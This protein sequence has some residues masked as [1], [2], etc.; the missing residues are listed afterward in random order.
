M[1]VRSLGVLDLQD[2]VPVGLSD[3]S[4]TTSS[5]GRESRTGSGQSRPGIAS[6]TSKPLLRSHRAVINLPE[7]SPLTSESGEIPAIVTYDRERA[8]RPLTS[9][10][11]Y[12]TAAL[13][14]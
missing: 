13:N 2:L 6:S 7:W 3:V 12:R 1:S 5:E 4:S 14:T 11:A 10:D 8:A 9:N